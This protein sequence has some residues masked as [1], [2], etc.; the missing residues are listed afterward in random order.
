MPHLRT[1]D[2][3]FADL[4]DYDF[5]PHYVE[6][7]DP[8][9]PGASLRVHYLDEGPAD[10][11][12]VLLLHGEPSWCYL[13]RHMIGP[14]VAAGFRCI[15]PDLVG[16]GR[17]DKPTDRSTHTYANHVEWMREALFDRLDLTA[18]TYFGQD[19]GG[20]I[21][22]RLV[23]EHPEYFA[24]VIVSNTGLNTGDRG[25]GKEFLA[26]QDYARTAVEFPIGRIVAGGVLT[27]LTDAEIAAYDA[28]FPS[29]EYTVAPR[30]M[31]SLVPTTS[32]NPASQANRDAWSTLESWDKPFLIAFSDS[33]PLTAGGERSF[34][35]VP[36]KV[37][38][39]LV[40]EGASH[41]VQEDKGPEL[42][43]IIIDFI[44]G[45]I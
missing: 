41:F 10:G 14:L 6:V 17:S 20:L 12:V 23:G 15:A 35:K 21:G 13:Y 31:P 11:P 18:I 24:R 42:A 3:C 34:L 8:A 44:A 7:A 27:G 38:Q 39:Q 33:D 1:P 26:W 4:P 28:P 40:V 30:T 32:D 36:E 9:E 37:R 29:D 22:L 5:A 2:D 45:T 43:A 19:W 25:A 16:F